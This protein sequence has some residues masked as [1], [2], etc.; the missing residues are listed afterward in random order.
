MVELASYSLSFLTNCSL[1]CHSCRAAAS[2]QNSFL[3]G[4][5]GIFL[6]VVRL[7][8]NV[9]HCISSTL[10]AWGRTKLVQKKLGL[11]W[12]IAKVVLFNKF[13]FY[14]NI[15]SFQ[16]ASLWIILMSMEKVFF[17]FAVRTIHFPS[18]NYILYCVSSQQE[19]MLQIMKTSH[20]NK[21]D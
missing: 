17:S 2:V 12:E 14:I 1:K 7:W 13:A 5:L 19:S 16:H 15:S 3:E 10:N 21:S 18:L 4:G 8:L 11:F 9:Q 6:F 20:V